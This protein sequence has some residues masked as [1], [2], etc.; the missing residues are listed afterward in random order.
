MMIHKKYY[1]SP[2]DLYRLAG[3]A[4][5]CY[6]NGKIYVFV[7]FI[8]EKYPTPYNGNKYGRYHTIQYAHASK[9]GQ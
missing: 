3:G 7:T 4:T 1:I 2:Y 9:I 8:C 6:I 5:V